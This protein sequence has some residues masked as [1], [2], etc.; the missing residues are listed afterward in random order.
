MWHARWGVFSVV[1][2]GAAL[3]KHPQTKAVTFTGSFKGG[4]S[5][6]Q[7]AQERAV[8]IPVFAEM[9]SINPVVLLPQ[10][11]HK[12][13]DELAARYAASITMGAGQFCTNPGL[14]LAIQ[15][16]GLNQ[17]KSSL[18]AAIKKIQP[19]TMLTSGI[20]NN[21]QSLSTAVLA[22]K[23]ISI[24]AQAEAVENDTANKAAALVVQVAAQEFLSNP[25]LMEEVFG[26]FS[27][28]VVADDE[29]QLNA[30][31]NVLQGQLTTTVMAEEDELPEYTGLLNKL[32]NITGRLILNGVPTGVEVCAA[33]QHGGPY[34]ATNDS[35]Y[36]SVGSTAIYRFVRPLA[37]QDWHPLLLP[38]ELKNSNPLNIW[39][40][41]DN[42]WTKE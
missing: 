20:F 24:L 37:W 25:K 1:Q 32:A 5:L 41:I 17:F 16:D 21:Y 35:R 28:L 13:A 30:V 19:A 15:S 22:E 14:L 9:G 33:M 39:R 40:L 4:T 29:N 7:L 42:K 38:D 36:T 12:R 31:A 3:V 8:P 11:L 18:T 34:P 6:I 10:A 2:V 23:G 26:P 27:L